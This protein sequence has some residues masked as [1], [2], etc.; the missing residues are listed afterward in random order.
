MA[1]DIVTVNVSR[2]LAPAPAMFQRRG[3][4]VSV[5]G[6]TLAPG[7]TQILLESQDLTGILKPAG[8]G[9]VELQ[10]AG[11]TYFAQ[12]SSVAVY[13]LELGPSDTPA[14]GVAAL[15]AYLQENVKTF[16][17]YLVPHAWAEEPTYKD[18]V[19]LYTANTAMQYFFTTITSDDFTQSQTGLVQPFANIKSVVPFIESE[20]PALSTDEFSVA[21]MFFKALSYNPSTV[22][23]IT[24]MAFSFLQDVTVGSWSS[25]LLTAFNSGSVN[26]ADTG[27]EG[28]VSDT[29]LKFGTTADGRDYTY[30]YAVDWAQINVKMDLANEIINGSNNPLNPLYYDQDGINRLRIRAQQTFNRGITYGLFQGPITVNAVDFLTYTSDNPSDYPEGIYNGLSVTV[31]PKRGFRSITFNLNVSDFITS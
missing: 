15:K 7:Y 24:P 28:G 2:T 27:A 10:A 30:W 26:Y 3:A 29:I 31:I 6:T 25:S 21:A 16:Y 17:G 23:K 9:V 19:K 20:A 22:N 18:L 12:G 4:I 1:N 13:V 5:G 11:D 14:A 8:A